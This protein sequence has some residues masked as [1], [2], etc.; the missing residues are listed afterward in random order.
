MRRLCGLL[1]FLI[2]VTGCGCARQPTNDPGLARAA[3]DEYVVNFWIKRD[4]SALGRAL[5]PTMVY[6]YN[7]R[8]IAGDPAA[9][10]RALQSFGGAFPDLRATVDVLTVSGDVGAAV[11][12]WSGTHTGVLCQTPGSGKK[13][14][15]V[16]NYVFRI[17]GGRIVELWE[18]WDEGGTY[19]SLGV[20]PAKCE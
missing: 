14:S 9:H 3:L 17:S 20:D 16:V 12:S 6:H 8:I 4:T 18:A 7:G 1:N 2:V 5:A 15:W 13:V 11:T 19:R 10:L